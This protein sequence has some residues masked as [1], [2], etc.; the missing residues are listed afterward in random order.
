MQDSAWIGWGLVIVGWVVAHSFAKSRDSQA[1][2]DSGV[3]EL[4]EETKELV[5]QVRDLATTYH[6]QP[7]DAT[8]ERELLFRLKQLSIRLLTICRIAAPH[9]PLIDRAM[10]ELRQAIS[11]SHFADEHLGPIE[12]NDQLLLNVESA[13]FV[14]LQRL[15]SA[16]IDSF[17]SFKSSPLQI[18][19]Q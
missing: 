16:Y 3:R 17:S 5:E 14:L 10:K 15:D 4:I 9:K 1:A 11:R 8:C 18:S 6:V 13:L 19:T 2:L 7:R 12:R